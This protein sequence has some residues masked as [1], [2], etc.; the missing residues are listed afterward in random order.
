M[1]IPYSG[2]SRSGV[3]RLACVAPC[4]R[5]YFVERRGPALEMGIMHAD[6]GLGSGPPVRINNLDGAEL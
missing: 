5:V 3:V 1:Y 6:L 2:D 4:T